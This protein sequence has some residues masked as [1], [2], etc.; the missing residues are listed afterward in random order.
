MIRKLYPYFQKYK[1]YLFFSFALLTVDVVGDL[2]IP[3]L[4]SLIVDVGI[5]NRDVR[6]IVL[7]GLLM[8]GLAGINIVLGTTNMKLS[9]E[10]SQGFA[11]DLRKALFNHVQSF[12]FSNLDRFSPASLVTRLT[13]DV[14]QL[15]MTVMMGLRVFMRSPL[16]LICALIFAMRINLRLSL[17]VLVA[18]PLLVVGTLL[19]MR[20]AEKLFTSVQRKLDRL[21]GT[22]QENLVAIRVVK[23][24]VRAEHEKKKFRK[25]NDSLM[26]TAMRAGNLVSLTMP[27]MMLILNAATL[28][29]IWRGG[30]LV[31]AGEMGAGKLISFIGYLFLILMSFMMFSMIFI[32]LAR[33]EASGKR[34][35]EVLDSRPEITDKP[36]SR[37]DPLRHRVTE[38]RIEFRNVGFRYGGS[39]GGKDV[40]SDISFTVEPGR[41][42]AIIGGT[43][44]GKTTLVSLIPRLY[45]VT[46]GQ[47]LVDGVGVRDYDLKT[48]RSGIG[49][50]LQKN[51][52][53]SGTIRDNLLWGSPSAG[54]DEIREAADAAQAQEFIESFPEGYDTELGEGGV[55]VSGG[56]KQRLCIA[57]ALLKH[58]PILILD[59]S[60]SAVDTATEAKIRRALQKDRRKMT[61]LIIAQRISSVRDADTIL[62]LDGGKINGM[63]THEELYR[64]N[65]IYREICVS[66]QEGVVS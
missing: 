32:L 21:N 39:D 51:V 17:I 48:L 46:S 8:V 18:L 25:A 11:A 1:N 41:V 38:G 28:A 23:A 3:Y 34:I 56:Q 60:T 53:F 33:A 24:F 36:G 6:Y 26:E 44:S 12:S 4:M 63:G 40:L 10:A 50:V 59:D 57:R 47:V 14:T 64:G 42:V 62:V 66:Q 13:S 5:P 65:K 2:L 29:V 20:T 37:S 30:H 35:V 19:I 15:Q 58:P 54:E 45:D 55:N 22:I 7:I 49:M 52:L 16:M 31:Y 9:A 43:G 61:V 27:L